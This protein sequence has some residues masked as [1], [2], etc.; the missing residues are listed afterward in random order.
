MLA[1]VRGARSKM[2]ESAATRRGL[3][4]SVIWSH[5]AELLVT[6]ASSRPYVDFLDAL[7]LNSIEKALKMQRA[8][9]FFS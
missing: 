1:G 3:G 5:A 2:W 7:Q 6:R 8:E 4:M 9:P